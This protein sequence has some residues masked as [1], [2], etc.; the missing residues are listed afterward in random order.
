MSVPLLAGLRVDV[1]TSARYLAATINVTKNV[2]H[3]VP[4]RLHLQSASNFDMSF[5]GSLEVPDRIEVSL[6]ERIVVLK[7]T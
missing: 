4:V 3:H 2:R 5:A 6:G 1:R 7:R